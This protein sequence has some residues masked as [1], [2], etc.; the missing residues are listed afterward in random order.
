MSFSTGWRQAMQGP[1]T[2]NSN[3]LELESAKQKC[4]LIG[5]RISF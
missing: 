1:I 3:L 5:I 4:Q 2:Q